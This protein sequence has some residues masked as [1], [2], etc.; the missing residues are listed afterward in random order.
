MLKK[1]IYMYIK[2]YTYQKRKYHTFVQQNF[3]G[4][5][6]IETTGFVIKP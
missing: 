1:H 2:I 3:E 5:T 6:H 4:G